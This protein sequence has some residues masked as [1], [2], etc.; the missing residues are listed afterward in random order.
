MAVKKYTTDELEHAVAEIQAGEASSMRAVA[1]KYG[2][3]HSTLHDHLKGSPRRLVLELQKCSDNI[4][5]ERN[6]P[7][8]M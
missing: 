8:N 2:V 1:N 3:S 4:R 6:S 7:I 5:G